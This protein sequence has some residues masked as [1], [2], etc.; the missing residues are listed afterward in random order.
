MKTTGG[1][2]VSLQNKKVEKVAVYFWSICCTTALYMLSI[3]K[4]IRSEIKK[5]ENLKFI[6]PHGSRQPKKWKKGTER[7][8]NLVKYF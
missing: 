6:C 7:E 4:M 5:N 1:L 8:R 3:K 2:L